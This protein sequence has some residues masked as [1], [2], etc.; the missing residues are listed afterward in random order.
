MKR[1]IRITPSTFLNLNLDMTNEIMNP[2]RNRTN[3]TKE[4]TAPSLSTR[5]G[6]PQKRLPIND[7]NGNLEV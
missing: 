2:T 5:T 7:G 1:M 3:N 6:L 4:H